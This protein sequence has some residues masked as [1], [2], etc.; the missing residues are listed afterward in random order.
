MEIFGRSKRIWTSDPYPPKSRAFYIRSIGGVAEITKPIAKIDLCLG[1]ATGASDDQVVVMHTLAPEA[2][3]GQ[4]NQHPGRYL[5][6]RT[7]RGPFGHVPLTPK[8]IFA[9]L[10]GV[11]EE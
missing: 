8:M 11:S 1:F 3:P 5:E 9:A 4:G 6:R 10:G 2:L 7:L